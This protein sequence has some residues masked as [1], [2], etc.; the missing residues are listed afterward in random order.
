MQVSR[1]DLILEV[2][3]E[4]Q[5]FLVFVLGLI[6]GD[7]PDEVVHVARVELAGVYGHGAGQVYGTD[8]PDP[9]VLDGLPGLGELAVAPAL[10]REVDDDGPRLHALDHILV[11]ELRGLHAGNER[12]RDDYVH[13]LHA[14]PD[15][16]LVLIELL[17]GPPFVF[18]LG[19]SSSSSSSPSTMYRSRGGSA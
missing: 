5:V 7:V 11:H 1:D 6:F 16:L 3:V 12:R 13:L 17:L 4:V 10:G 9:L 14:L 8:D 15:E 19:A 18:L 2:Q